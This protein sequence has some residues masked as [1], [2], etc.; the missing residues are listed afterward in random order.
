M[1]IKIWM[2]FHAKMFV[3]EFG[4]NLSYD[5][6]TIKKNGIVDSNSETYVN[7]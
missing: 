7:F 5:K 4:H 2:N 3:K 1:E 6:K